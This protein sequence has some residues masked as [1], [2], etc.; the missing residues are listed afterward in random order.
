[1]KKLLI[2]L[3]FPC[4]ALADPSSPFD[5]LRQ[6][7]PEIQ[8]YFQSLVVRSLA[9]DVANAMA[10][11]GFS[12]DKIFAVLHGPDF[13]SF[14]RHVVK[15]PR[16]EKALNDLL[17]QLL[18]PGALEAMFQKKYRE[19]A[20]QQQA[21]MVLAVEELLRAQRVGLP[22][23]TKKEPPTFWQKIWDHFRKALFQ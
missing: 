2:A 9:N 7:R 11:N 18:A 19:L 5:R 12:D 22:Q 1:M 17:D 21:S 13:E 23:E 15:S 4:I 3:L 6:E 14:S 8:K 10:A 20:A 16:V